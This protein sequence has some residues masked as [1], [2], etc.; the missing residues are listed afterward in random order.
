[1]TEKEICK[2]LKDLTIFPERTSVYISNRHAY[3]R[4][5][6]TCQIGYDELTKISELLGTTDINFQYDKGWSGTEVTPGDP[7]T[8]CI[9]I[10][11]GTILK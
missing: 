2:K 6:R 5:D 4:I 9:V 8:F 1:M 10:G 7:P 11:L 3:I